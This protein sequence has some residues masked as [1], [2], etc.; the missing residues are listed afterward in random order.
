MK[1]VTRSSK[2]REAVIPKIWDLADRRQLANTPTR[3]ETRHPEV[4]KS[5]DVVLTHWLTSGASLHRLWLSNLAVRATR[6]S[7]DAPFRSCVETRAI[8]TVEFPARA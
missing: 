6:H 5:M 4:L 1:P 7:Y 3:L 2:K 8:R